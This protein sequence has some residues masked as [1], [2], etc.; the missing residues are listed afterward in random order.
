MLQSDVVLE[1]AKRY[2]KSP[3]QI[4]LRYIIQNGIAVIPKSTNP[5]RIKENTQLFGWKLEPQDIKKL[6]SLDRGESGRIC[7]F[8]FFKGI[9]HHPEF[10]F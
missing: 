2:N 9:R 1:I 7:D 6:K 4:L 5:Q 8:G 10:P 3:A